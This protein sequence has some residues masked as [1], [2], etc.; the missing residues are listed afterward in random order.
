MFIKIILACSFM[1]DSS[2]SAITAAPD[3]FSSL[4]APQTPAAVMTPQPAPHP[5]AVD[6]RAIALPPVADDPVAQRAPAI[7]A[8]PAGPIAGIVTGALNLPTIMP[9]TKRASAGEVVEKVQVFYKGTKRLR[10]K[11]R[12]TTFQKVMGRKQ[13]SDGMVYIKKPGMMRWDY[14]K[15]KK[16]KKTRTSKS[17]ISDGSQMW[18]VFHDD[19]QFMKK[20]LEENL[21]PVAVTFLYG[22]GDLSKDFSAKFASGGKYG[23]KTDYVLELSPRKPSAQYKK[24]YLVVS[25]DNFR[26]T[27]SIVEN[28]EGDTNHFRFYEPNTTKTIKT[29]WFV[30][31]EKR[32]LKMDYREAT[33]PEAPKK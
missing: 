9:Q 32:A 27:Q 26:V 3:F 15:K 16:G 25:P 20:K 33:P 31:A 22:K 8:A 12:Q 21:L 10:A 23:K 17:F 30:F 19:K 7:S 2:A 1:F 14:K 18:A 5:P 24:L 28:S 11:F 29:S 6:K 4:S 13:T